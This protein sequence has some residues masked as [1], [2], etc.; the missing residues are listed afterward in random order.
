MTIITLILILYIPVS[1]A[2]MFA[3][4]KGRIDT[5]EGLNLEVETQR[6][7]RSKAEQKL[8]QLESEKKQMEKRIQTLAYNNSV[9]KT[10]V[11]NLQDA[12][13]IYRSNAAS[14]E[15]GVF[16]VIEEIAVNTNNR[17]VL[18]QSD[19][20]KLTNNVGETPQDQPMPSAK[21]YEFG[22]KK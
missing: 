12:C 14:E 1:L 10:D 5:T 19:I 16:E 13:R 4:A 15:G 7:H 20:D 3:M 6:N 22:V 11:K 2:I 18:S 17:F 9:L 21:V 8:E